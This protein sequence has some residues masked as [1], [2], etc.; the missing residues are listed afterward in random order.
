MRVVKDHRA[1]QRFALENGAVVQSRAGVFNAGAH[2][3]TVQEEAP[4]EVLK[5]EPPPL[6]PSPNVIV[7][8]SGVERA[9]KEASYK[10]ALSEEQL[11]KIL[12]ALAGIDQSVIKVLTKEVP[13]P[14]PPPKKRGW[15]MKFNRDKFGV[16]ES[17]NVTPKEPPVG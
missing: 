5:V 12:E 14:P 8:L 13:V 2:R 9:I 15:D 4:K 1:L 3:A 6:P 11:K 7:D 16:I 10:A 17:I